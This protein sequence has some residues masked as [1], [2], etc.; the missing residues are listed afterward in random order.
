MSNDL[1]R[2]TH[3]TLTLIPNKFLFLFRNY[4]V[5]FVILCHDIASC[6]LHL[7]GFAFTI[8]NLHFR[9][10]MK[11]IFNGKLRAYFIPFWRDE[12]GLSEKYYYFLPAK[13]K[14][15]FRINL[16]R[17]S[18][19]KHSFA[20]KKINRLLWKLNASACN[21]LFYFFSWSKSIEF[22]LLICDVS[23]ERTQRLNEISHRSDL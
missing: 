22:I 15:N 2:R 16:H 19:N 14:E 6:H 21:L 7:R 13:R 10:H 23:H 8:W 4:S 20:T 18:N 3:E 11:R 12:S 9:A 5:F 17:M 1:D